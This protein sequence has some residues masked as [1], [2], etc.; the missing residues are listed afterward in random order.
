MQKESPANA[1][2][3]YALPWRILVAP[4]DSWRQLCTRPSP[5]PALLTQWLLLVLYALVATRP[6]A[7]LWDAAGLGKLAS[8]DSNFGRWLGILLLYLPL[9]LLIAALTAVAARFALLLV[10]I[11]IDFRQAL[12]WTAYSALPVYLGRCLGFLGFSIVQPLARDAQD[13][14]AL[15]FSPFSPGLAGLFPPLS[16]P[17][18]MAS[19]FDLFGIWSLIL[20][21]LGARHFLALT[22]SRSAWAMLVIMLLWLAALTV[23]WRGMLAAPV[24]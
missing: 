5:W 17:W 21:G 2:S 10:A 23:V 3:P 1:A 14:W 6:L 18:V 16:Y 15:M 22:P 20:L 8:G 12:T 11:R 4:V 7:E 9:N 19:S 13:V 24:L